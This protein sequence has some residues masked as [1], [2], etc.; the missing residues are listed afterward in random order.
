MI[1]SNDSCSTILTEDSTLSEGFVKVD[2]GLDQKSWEARNER[3]YRLHLAHHYHS[4]C[5]CFVLGVE[6]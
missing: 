1:P 6:S 4:T 5:R 3:R 2:T